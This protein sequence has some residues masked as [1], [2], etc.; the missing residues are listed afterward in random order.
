[1]TPKNVLWVKSVPAGSLSFPDRRP[2]CACQPFP[3][4]AGPCSRGGFALF[5]LERGSCLG[6]ALIAATRPPPHRSQQKWQR[7]LDWQRAVGQDAG[8]IGCGSA[9]LNNRTCSELPSPAAF[10]SLRRPYCPLQKMGQRLIV[11]Q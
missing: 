10:S 6:L 9:D 3:G 11:L 2:P 5:S 8:Y 4:L 1:M 7:A